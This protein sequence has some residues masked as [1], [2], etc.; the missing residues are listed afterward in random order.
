MGDTPPQI[1][2]QA[3]GSPTVDGCVEADGRC[4]VCCGEMVRG[5]LTSKV[6]GKSFTDHA[7]VKNPSGS[8]ICEA[9]CCVMSRTSPVLGRDAKDG[10][11]FGANFRNV[12]HLW[13]HGW[14]GK[15]APGYQNCSKGEKPAMRAF[16]EREHAAT[17]FAALG[18]SGQRHV[19]PFATINGPGRAGVV[20]FDEQIVQ[21]P[22]DTSLI[23]SMTDLLTAG[24]TKAEIESGRFG[25]GAWR[26][27]EA[28]IRE[29]EAANKSYRGTPWFTLALW[30]AQ[31]DEEQVQA[32]LA[33]EKEERDAKRI[34]KSAARRNRQRAGR[35][36]QS[37]YADSGPQPSET[38]APAGIG[39]APELER[40]GN[41]GAVAGKNPERAQDHE[42]AQQQEQLALFGS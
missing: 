38:L 15:Q 6:L 28:Q 23:A 11:K 40:S 26:R 3:H 29:F 35:P 10:K 42:H 33:R 8:H 13:E 27:C 16:L 31:R 4:F 30:L 19:L 32:R 1:V 5:M 2:W 34:R 37:V 24:A 14:S 39:V 22:R 36:E 18:D 41:D 7:R 12:S 21:V 17:W 20:L 25:D 9:C